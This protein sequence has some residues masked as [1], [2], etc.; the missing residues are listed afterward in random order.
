M[1]TTK[2]LLASFKKGLREV[3]ERMPGVITS[4]RSKKSEIPTQVHRELG[5]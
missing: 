2:V 5:V 3:G 1:N 4:E